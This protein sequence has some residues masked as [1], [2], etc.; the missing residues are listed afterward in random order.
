MGRNVTI[1]MDPA[2]LD[3]LKKDFG[4]QSDALRLIV[5]PHSRL[6][7]MVMAELK[8]YFSRAELTALIDSQNGVLLTPD[9]IYNKVFFLAQLEDFETL[10]DGI[11]RHGADGPDLLQKL[12]QL[13]HA[14]VYFLMLDI[15]AFWN[16][17]DRDLNNYLDTY[18]G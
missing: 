13:S 8:G 7:K 16:H 10:E 11:S 4:Q 14:Q 6:R 15:A 9:F 1:Q 18:A 5:E 2:E 12:K 17:N 3:Q